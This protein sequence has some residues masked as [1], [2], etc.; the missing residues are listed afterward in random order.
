MCRWVPQLIFMVAMLVSHRSTPQ[1]LIVV[2]APFFFPCGRKNISTTRERFIWDLVFF[3]LVFSLANEHATLV[4]CSF[5]L[6]D[7]H[8]CIGFHVVV[9]MLIYVVYWFPWSMCFF[10]KEESHRFKDCGPTHGK[11]GNNSLQVNFFPW[12][13]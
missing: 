2:Y 3:I 10:C 8:G 6:I 7:F 11:I 12:S 13:C 4:L 1:V 9:V 5:R